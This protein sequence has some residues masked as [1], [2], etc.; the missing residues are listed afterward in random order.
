MEITISKTNK[1]I[2]QKEISNLENDLNIK[3]PLNMKTFLLEYNGGK[4]EPND[5]EIKETNSIAEI[6]EFYC[7]EKIKKFKNEYSKRITEAML[8]FAEDSCGNLFCVETETGLGGVYFWDHEYEENEGVTPTGRNE[9]LIAEDFNKFLFSIK[10]FDP[11][12]VQLDWDAVIE[13]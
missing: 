13:D 1:N 12:S 2:S 5:V 11:D 4:P 7:I 3:I 8:P 10:K 9:K 6:R